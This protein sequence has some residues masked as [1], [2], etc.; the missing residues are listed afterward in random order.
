MPAGPGEKAGG[1][2]GVAPEGVPRVYSRL[3]DCRKVCDFIDFLQA[4]R[5]IALSV[6]APP[7][8]ILMHKVNPH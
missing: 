3:R 7:L 4:H 8:E 5:L 2:A 6:P 1:G